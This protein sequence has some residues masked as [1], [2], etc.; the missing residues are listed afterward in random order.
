MN[1]YKEFNNIASKFSYW[2]ENIK[3]IFRIFEGTGDNQII[4]NE[5][6]P[7]NFH[8]KDFIIISD[9]IERGLNI[10][11]RGLRQVQQEHEANSG[12]LFYFS[13]YGGSKTQFLNLVRD[14]INTKLN[15]CIVV[16]FEDIDHINPI[17]LFNY[18]FSQIFQAIAKMPELSSDTLNY[19]KFT[20]DL[21]KYISEIHVSIRQSS[22]L[23]KAEKILINLKKVKNPELLRQINEL[24]EL[25]HSTIL[26]DSVKIL[27]EIINLMQFC[28]LNNIIFL[29][30]FDEV[31]LWLEERED[32]LKF[33]QEFNKIS[34]IMKNI[35]EIPD[36]KVKIF[37]V[38]ACTDRVNRL[39][40]TMQS[41]FETRSNV[42][43]RLNRIFNS[44]DKVLEPGKYG[45]KIE[46]A[47]VSIAAYYH[48]AND[49]AKVD[50][51]I[52]EKAVPILD[53]KYKALSRRMANSKIIQ[54]LKSYQVLSNPLE[55]GLKNW[56]SNITHYGT[57]IQRNL[58]G[59]LNRLTIKFIRKDI[60]VDPTSEK[61]TKDKIDGYF[62]NYSLENEEIRTYV[63][64]KLT[65]E[66]KGIKAYQALQFLQLRPEESCVMIIFSPTTLK[67]IKEEV[68]EYAANQG[69][70]SSVLNRLYYILIDEPIGFCA[71]DG[72]NKVS[73]DSNKLLEY[74]EAYAK[75][76]EF[77]SSFSSQY[78]EIKQKIGI[79]FIVPTK[80]PPAEPQEEITDDGKP[81]FE[82][83]SEQQTCL[84][85]LSKLFHM[86]KFSTSG[87]MYKKTIQKFIEDQSLGITDIGKYYE[88]MKESN[89]VTG[90]TNS[91]ITFSEKIININ[92][93]EDLRQKVFNFFHK[94]SK[95][96]EMTYFA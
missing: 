68:N 22:N 89:I 72:I 26:V 39:F 55:T 57:L 78:Q 6:V 35:F 14:E 52:L 58:P 85:L 31:D 33:S 17:N 45:S 12:S 84:N 28:S 53:E 94:S 54:L 40:Q 4:T 42:A 5:I 23:K 16:L 46:N 60:P 69:Y 70:S 30:L 76:L 43:S 96:M 66:F 32:D 21:M 64:I 51:S 24:D 63:E 74:L 25:L 9:E 49:N 1:L 79:D 7:T 56:K 75:W 37:T 73:S 36:N 38:F 41:K 82:L 11:H 65:K 62:V 95:V 18:I 87:R 2:E 80:K 13:Q 29:F 34:K 67:N 20:N 10:I 91:T 50:T 3:K 81:K 15:N 86:K 59:I 88:T 90:I 8:I 19:Q 92:G 47:L 27:N 44:A 77:F 83:S 48:L 71:I 61:I 93:L